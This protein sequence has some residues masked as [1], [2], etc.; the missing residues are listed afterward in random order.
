MN[1]PSCGF[2]A[3]D[4]TAECP[5][6]G[7][8][9]AKWKAMVDAHPPSA[10]TLR[11]GAGTTAA[12][13]ALTLA[14]VWLYARKTIVFPAPEPP[15]PAP[16]TEKLYLWAAAQTQG[17]TLIALHPVM[18]LDG[19]TRRQIYDLRKSEL[20]RHPELARPDYEPNGNIFG[21]ILDGKPWWGLEGI[22]F[23]GGGKMSI[24]GPSEESRFIANPLLLVGIRE[25]VARSGWSPDGSAN[26]YPYPTRLAWNGAAAS[27]RATYNV[28]EHFDFTTNHHYPDDKSHELELALYNASDL[29]FRFFALDR[30]RSKG[31]ALE[32][33]EGRPVMIL[34]YIHCGGSCGYPGG[35]NNMSPYS[36]DYMIQVPSLPAKAVFKLWKKRPK[37]VAAPA[38]MTYTIDMN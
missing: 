7:V 20:K 24:A 27:A 1:C 9:F 35:C 30:E 38:D 26:Y 28:A 15:A 21:A 34:Q 14:A 3:V 33:H 8:I 32:A 12:V 5:S 37:D 13:L 19:D 25:S 6:C 29:G 16:E 36:A 2:G 10:P 18:K 17:E 22:Y 11:A 23:Y 31:V 4:G